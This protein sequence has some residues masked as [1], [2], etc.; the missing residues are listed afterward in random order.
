MGWLV[1]AGWFSRGVP[2]G[3]QSDGGWGCGHLKAWRGW[4]S[5]V[6]H[7]MAAGGAGCQLG[8]QLQFST[9]IPTSGFF[10]CLGLL[11]AA[12]W[13][14]RG[15]IPQARVPR[16]PGRCFQGFLCLNF[17]RPNRSVLLMK[18]NLLCVRKR[19]TH[20]AYKDKMIQPVPLGSEELI[21]T[22]DMWF[23]IWD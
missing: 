12:G 22:I 7:S 3:K 17:R 1:S 15:S 9:R 21:R 4:T 18:A 11:T 5:R 23:H 14:L 10:L 13:V 6:A 16:E 19:G 20:W 8:A 2:Q